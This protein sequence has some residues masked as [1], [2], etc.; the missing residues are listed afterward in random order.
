LGHGNSEPMPAAGNQHDMHSGFMGTSQCLEI[1]CR[2]IQRGV[3]ESAIDVHCNQANRG[4][5]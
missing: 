4:R 2:D 1:G 5:H 3:D